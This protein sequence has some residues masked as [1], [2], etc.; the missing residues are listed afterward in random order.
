MSCCRPKRQKPIKKMTSMGSSKAA[1]VK[2]HGPGSSVQ[3]EDIYDGVPNHSTKNT[4]RLGQ[5]GTAQVYRIVHKATK[6]QYAL[7]IINL[8]TVSNQDKKS[9]LLQE[10]PI[11]TVLDHP[12][13]I[14]VVEVFRKL[15]SIYIVMELCTGGELF[16]RLYSQPNDRFQEAEA[17][18]LVRKMLSSLSYLHRNGIVHRDLKLEN[19]IFTNKTKD[20]DIKLI[21][22]GFSTQYL[23]GASKLNEVVG[24][25][26]YIAPEVLGKNYTQQSDLWSLG[27]VVFMMVTGLSPFSGQGNK[28]IMENVKAKCKDP[29][30]LKEELEL[31]LKDAGVSKECIDFTMGLMTVDPKQRLTADTGLEHPWISKDDFLN[32]DD[33][34]A[35]PAP[36]SSAVARVEHDTVAK[37]KQNMSYTSLQRSALFA[38]AFEMSSTQL[39]SLNEAFETLDTNH[40]GTISFS[41]FKACLKN[42]GVVAPKAVKALFTAADRDHS[43]TLQYSEFLGAAMEIK[44]AQDTEK[45]ELAFY[46]L[47]LDDSGDLSREELASMIGEPL[48][49]PAVQK[50]L[51]SADL[52]KDGKISRDEFKKALSCRPMTP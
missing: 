14:K 49:S 29:Q 38:M 37:M 45:V 4:H 47:D 39:Q 43:G 40:N 25:C 41:E 7:K 19:F 32:E 44:T 48:D 6:T 33:K 26:Y 3:I 9:M 18:F 50:V 2:D 16:D 22:F 42:C 24:T 1:L 31:D 28:Q 20:A 30:A 5:G 34:K 13:V 8:T 12:N 35:R 15:I 36:S 27:V 51:D 10:I 11:I 52:D 21:D 17:R 23:A 46:R